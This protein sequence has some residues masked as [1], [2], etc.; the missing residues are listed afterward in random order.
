MATTSLPVSLQTRPFSDWFEGSWTTPT[1]DLHNWVVDVAPAALAPLAVIVILA[2]MLFF[3]SWL[4]CS[5]DLRCRKI[6]RKPGLFAGGLFGMLIV[7]LALVVWYQLLLILGT[8][9]SAQSE[10]IIATNEVSLFA[11]GDAAAPR[12]ATCAS[13]PPPP[14]CPSSSLIGFAEAAQAT[15]SSTTSRATAF[16]ERLEH[17][18]NVVLPAV[19]SATDST[20]VL[21][22]VLSANIS[23]LN[24]TASL[25]AQAFMNAKQTAS[26]YTSSSPSAP[27]AWAPIAFFDDLPA[28]PE[29]AI[30][31]SADLAAQLR[32]EHT[33]LVDLTNGPIVTDASRLSSEMLEQATSMNSTL[34]DVVEPLVE[35]ARDLLGTVN[36]A[37]G[38][39]EGEWANIGLPTGGPPGGGSPQPTAA[40]PTD[41]SAPALYFVLG[42]GA[43]LLLPALFLLCASCCKARGGKPWGTLACGCGCCALLALPLLLL[44]TA[45]GLIASPVL[46]AACEPGVIMTLIRTNLRNAGNVTLLNG[47]V[48]GQGSSVA[49]A[50]LVPQMLECGSAGG[51]TNWLELIGADAT[52]DEAVGL[53]Q[54]LTRDDASGLD[55]LNETALV[56]IDLALAQ[57]DATVIP[58]QSAFDSFDEAAFN[59]LVT[60]WATLEAQLPADT[61]PTDPTELVQWRQKFYALYGSDV[62]VGPTAAELADNTFIRS[63]GNR[64]AELAAGIPPT[65]AAVNLTFA[66]VP[67]SV[68]GL[69][70]ELVNSRLVFS[71][72]VDLATSLRGALAGSVELLESTDEMASCEW[73]GRTFTA[74]IDLTCAEETS[75]KAQTQMIGWLGF[76]SVVLVMLSSILLLCTKPRAAQGNWLSDNQVAP[77]SPGQPARPALKQRRGSSNY[78]P[79]DEI[80]LPSTDSMEPAP[81]EEGASSHHVVRLSN[82]GLPRVLATPIQSGRT[83]SSASVEEA[84]ALT[85]VSAATSRADGRGAR[86]ISSVAP[87][88]G[89]EGLP[90]CPY[91]GRDAASSVASRA[92]VV[93]TPV[94]LYPPVTSPRSP[95]CHGSF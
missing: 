8:A 44:L 67:S 50:T 5:C 48:D 45:F 47:G 49:L 88:A 24:Q 43:A 30:S 29:E 46:S 61:Q 75:L 84:Q 31:Q 83:I 89:P 93:G 51:A 7:A 22:E 9:N 86:C 72:A 85:R 95:A 69:R 25:A 11:C 27:A 91:T 32:V 64:A 81:S 90:A 23:S 10:A 2:F 80:Q 39:V 1:A 21:S 36:D 40:S 42:A 20:V 13:S 59:D 70:T 15:T 71:E 76:S 58:S 41:V 52:I 4:A 66:Q 62:V 73:I 74:V 18:I 53:V 77:G 12:L 78:K 65:V 14:V 37:C 82:S 54:N 17:A 3:I 55:Q 28:F 87:R 94:T 63:E 57:V 60:Q 68:D 92:S 16:I 19:I 34:S 26:K 35:S 6:P 38:T 56:A 33:T 79:F